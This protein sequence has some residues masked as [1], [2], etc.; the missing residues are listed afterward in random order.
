MSDSILNELITKQRIDIPEDRKLK[1]IDM[2]RM[3]GLLSDSIFYDNCSYWLGYSADK[4][5]Y[6]SYKSKKWLMHRLLFLNF[7]DELL[8]KYEYIHFT[9]KNKKCC[10]INHMKKCKYR[11]PVGIKH[12]KTND[13]I[14]K[15]H[16][17]II[18]K[19]EPSTDM[20]RIEFD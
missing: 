18:K 1:F 8:D 19:Q 12:D 3:A 9:C 4:Y 6:Y 16:E 13:P 10:S 11:I 5:I 2:K 7:K 17:P 15:T 14:I 20:F